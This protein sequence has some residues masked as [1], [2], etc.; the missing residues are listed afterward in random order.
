MKCPKCASELTI[1]KLEDV[2]VD[3]CKKCGGIWFDEDKLRQAKD[4]KDDD[5]RWMDF[6]LWKDTDQ[7]EINEDSSFCPKCGNVKT[8]ESILMMYYRK[9]K[10]FLMGKRGLYLN[11]KILRLLQNLCFTE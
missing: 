7:F 8:A 10:K 5:L 2:E 4:S 6:D 11:G 3:E 1:V 9:L